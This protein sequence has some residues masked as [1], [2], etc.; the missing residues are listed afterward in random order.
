MYDPRVNHAALLR[1]QRQRVHLLGQEGVQEDAWK[2]QGPNF[3]RSVSPRQYLHE[4][5]WPPSKITTFQASGFPG[6]G[7][8]QVEEWLS[9]V[10]NC[11][12]D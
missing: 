4:G 8:T 6:Y 5:G 1:C 3:G 10:P 9:E 7:Y 11:R 12:N 2:E